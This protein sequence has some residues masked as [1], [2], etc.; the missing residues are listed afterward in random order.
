[1]IAD[2]H[3]AATEVL[4]LGYVSGRYP[5]LD[6]IVDMLVLVTRGTRLAR[7][8]RTGSAPGSIS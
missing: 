1:M 8:W 5:D 2:L 6:E 4:A 7:A 3:I